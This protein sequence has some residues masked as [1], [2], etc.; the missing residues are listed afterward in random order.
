MYLLGKKNTMKNILSI[1][2]FAAI[3]FIA[4]CSSSKNGTN[5]KASNGNLAGTWTVSNILT[6]LPPNINITD[7]FDEAPFD[8]FKGST[9]QLV[10]NGNGSFTLANGNKQDI[11]WTIV[12]KDPNAQFQFKKLDGEK[13]RNVDEGYRLEIQ[14]ISANEF[15]ARSPVDVGGGN[16]GWISYTFTKQ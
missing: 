9:W 8:E 14:S 1:G 5:L 10:R 15:I 13:A 16:T 4:G 6:D 3:L 11:Y 2:L 12:G 7:V